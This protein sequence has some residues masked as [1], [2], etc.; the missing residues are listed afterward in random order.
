MLKLQVAEVEL[1]TFVLVMTRLLAVLFTAPPFSGGMVPTRVRLAVAVAVAFAVT[2]HTL[3]TQ[4]GEVEM[5]GTGAFMVAVVYQAVVGTLLGYVIQLLVSALQVAGAMIDFSAGL[6]A[7]SVFDPATQSQASPTSRLYQMMLLV[8]IV[9][10]DGHLL[11]IRG[12]VRSYEAA[13]LGGLR[14]DSIPN[15]LGEGAAQLMLAAIEVAFPVLVA[16]LLTEVVLGL[17]ARAAPKLNVMILGFASKSLIMM[18]TFALAV[19]LAVRATDSLFDRGVRWGFS[20][21]GG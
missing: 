8:L 10:T 16:L 11:L 4:A 17:A 3:A 5:M 1:L 13:P 18:I 7:A 20:L 21:V 19:P 14:L 15:V 6:S 9:V 12:V 2:P